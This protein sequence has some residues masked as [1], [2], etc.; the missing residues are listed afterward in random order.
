MSGQNRIVVNYDFDDIIMIGAININ[1]GKEMD[2]NILKE[3]YDNTFTIIEKI[4]TKLD[5]KSLKKLNL[6]NEEG[7]VIRFSNGNRMKI[8]FEEYFRLHKIL[9]GI[10][11]KTIWD[12]LR[13]GDDWEFL[14]EKVPD[15]FYEW[16]KDTVNSFNI[17]FDD[18]KETALK[19]FKIIKNTLLAL[20]FKYYRKTFA[21]L[22][23]E[24]PNT[25]KISGIM[26]A[27]LDE[28]DIDQMIWKILKP[29][30]STTFKGVIDETNAI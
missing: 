18:I 13:N 25:A 16:I 17:R 3:K 14:L 23:F 15:E 24:R 12:F 21:K 30:Q 29:K 8:K 22:V 1:N 11:D 28:K 9:T 4:N 20:N 2:Y 26:F 6:P 7:F 27:L 19:E 5:F 10:S